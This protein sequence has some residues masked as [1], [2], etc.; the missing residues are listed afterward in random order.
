MS[1]RRAYLLSEHMSSRVHMLCR[2]LA[3]VVESPYQLARPSDG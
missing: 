1:L 2:D 3:R